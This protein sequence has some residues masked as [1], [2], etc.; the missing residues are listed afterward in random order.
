MCASARRR[1]ACLIALAVA[2]FLAGST[3][4]GANKYWIGGSGQWDTI[5]N[6][7]SSSLPQ[8]DD[9]AYLTQSD[10]TD[11]VVTYYNTINPDAVLH[12]LRVDATGT[13]TMT[14]DMPNNHTLNV[15]YE[16]VGYDGQGAVTQS[17]GTNICSGI[18]VGYHATGNGTYTITGG[19]V[20]SSGALGVGT[21]GTGTLNILS[22]G[23]VYG[24]SGRMGLYAGSIGKATVD[25]IG[26][27]WSSS[28]WLVVGDHSTGTLDIKAGGQVSCSEGTIAWFGGGAATVDGNGSMWTNSSTLYVGRFDTGTLQIRNG[29]QVFDARGCLGIQPGSSGTATVDGIGSKWTNSA[30]M[31][32][33]DYGTGMLTIQNGGQI[34]VATG[35]KVWDN[36]SLTLQTGGSVTTGSLSKT[37]GGTITWTDGTLDIT[38]TGGLSVGPTGPLGAS[39]TLDAAKTLNVTNTLTIASGATL[40]LSGSSL[41]VGALS[42]SGTFNWTSG[43]LSITGTGGLT[44]GST[45]PLGAS[46]TLGSARTLNVTNTLSIASDATLSL[47]GGSVTAGMLSISGT[48]QADALSYLPV[49]NLALSG[50][51]L[52]SSGTFSRGVGAGNEQVQWTGSGGMSARGGKLTVALGGT[53]S[54]TPLVWASGNFVPSG[55]A[56]VFGSATADSETEFRNDIDLGGATRTVT[57][58]DNPASTGDFATLSGVLSNGGLTKSGTGLLVLRGANTYSGPTIVSEGTLRFGGAG[59]IPIGS[60]VTITGTLDIAVSGAAVNGLNGTGAVTLGSNTLTIGSAN[61]SGDF[62]GVISGTGGIIKSGQGVQALSGTDT[63]GGTSTIQGGVLRA[64]DGAGLPAASNLVLSGG[65]L[66]SIGTTTFTRTMGTTSGKVQWTGSGGFSACGGKMIVA[67]GGTGSPTAL[68]WGSGNFVPSGS[69]LVFGSATADSETEFRNAINFGGAARTITVNDNPATSADFATLTGVLS[70][71]SLL[72][73]GDGLL[74]L[75]GTNNYSGGTTIGGGTLR[76]TEGTTLP[77][78]GNLILAGGIFEAT[79]A[80]TFTRTLGTGGGQV[81]WTGSGGFSTKGAKLTVAIGGT[82]SPTALTWGSGGFVPDGCALVLGS[83]TAD[84]ETEFRNNLDLGGA[85]QTVTVNDN[86]ASGGDFANLSGVLSNGGLT[87]NGL[88]MLFLWGANTYAGTTTVAEGVLCVS[89]TSALGCAAGGTVVAGGSTLEV[90]AAV[91]AEPLT[92]NGPGVGGTGALRGGSSAGSWGGPVT[93]ASDSTLGA[94]AAPFTIYGAIGGAGGLTKIGMDLLELTASNSYSGTTT[95]QSGTLRAS[96]GEG[97]PAASN[98]VFAGG[99]FEG[100]GAT[101]FTRSMGTAGGQVRW[102]GSG[103]FSAY[104]GKTTVAI[105]GTASPTALTWGSGNFVPSGSALVFGSATADSEVVF[106][107][108]I[109]LG[110]ATRTITANDNAASGNDFATISGVLSNGGLTKNGLGIL[111]LS[112]ANTYA[113]IT[114]VAQGVLR[115]SHTA[116]L[117]STAASTTVSS[118]A[119]LEITVDGVAEPLTLN[120]TGVGGTGALRGGSSAATWS[121]PVTLASDSAIGASTAPLTVSGIISGVSR[122]LIKA[123]SGVVLLTGTN[124]YSGPTEVQGGV[125]R[126]TDGAGLPTSSN[127]VLSGGVLESSGATTFTRNMGTTAGKVQWTGSSGFSAYGGK[128]IVAIGGTTSPTALTWASGNF[129]PSGSALVFGSPTADSETEFR[130]A[131]N[132]GGATRTITVNDNPATTG[133]FA[134]LTGALTNGGLLKS[135]NG[136]LVLTGGNTYS[137]GTTIAGGTLRANDG[138]TLPAAG[139]LV[140]AGGVLEASSALTLTRGLGAGSGQVQWTAGG[141]FSAKG[142]KFTVAIGGTASPTALT[143]GSGG[144]V[145]SGSALIFGSPTADRETEFRNAIN[146]GG[147]VRTVTVIDNPAAPGDLASLSGVLSNGSLFKSG[148]GVLLLKVSPTYTGATTIAEGILRLMPSI[149]LASTVIEVDAGA[150]YDVSAVSGYSL[151]AGRVLKGE[152]T[153]LGNITVRGTMA[154]GSSPG[155]LSVTGSVTYANGSTL[156]IEIGGEER[157]ID[158]DVVDASGAITVASGATLSVALIDDF[159]PML[160]DEFDILDFSSITGEFTTYSLPAL[161]DGLAWDTSG[162]YTD[163]TIGVTPEPA[164]ILLLGMGCAL[165]VLR[166]RGR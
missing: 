73:S 26:S 144:F 56:L 58:N 29:G 152:G 86:P 28:G 68:T 115:L 53:A 128:M 96:D 117:G 74:V 165:V 145:P 87:K 3:A 57:V 14:L 37:S 159:L 157:G 118:G 64:T 41:E 46:P 7:S 147:D 113:G 108:S 25:G 76:A 116:A 65:V 78:A 36:S 22:G 18:N 10:A 163:G 107:N 54:P 24:S 127:L 129:V 51:V 139:N 69:A 105:G 66:E 33:G 81:Q 83:A 70:N 151:A 89:H 135:G 44:I 119:T 142:G 48:L 101:T 16:Y 80:T 6:W 125:L 132:F 61:G 59:A 162:I 34:T 40:T 131:I 85:T 32:V 124:T 72:K 82:A 47:S 13:G 137:G 95:I 123:D 150:T 27:K 52:S 161:G 100:N 5:G 166:R 154:P 90:S 138:T 15:L 23:Q 160:G 136:L 1:L 17:A 31:D 62:G 71:G 35:L 21:S 60:D 77:A 102:T 93:L 130:N 20:S 12:S 111:A 19:T 63:Y 164:S 141:G 42:N 106:T 30:N 149:T 155:V 79:G 88:G 158:Y 49:C 122:R 104:G 50:G 94:S 91:D 120:G 11:R 38:G 103:G 45:G 9:D 133:D 134:T 121:G 140:L 43:T 55:S 109:D 114:T 75:K 84:S 156:E 92:L 98:M 143:W 39:L 148:S 97:L 110:G 8:A 146:L 2:A 126:T 112:G 4:E 99:V 153:V 67:I